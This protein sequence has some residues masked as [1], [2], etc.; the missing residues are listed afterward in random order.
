MVCD[1]DSFRVADPL[2]RLNT[3][4]K[5]EEQLIASK[6]VLEM[7]DVKPAQQSDGKKNVFRKKPNNNNNSTLAHHQVAVL[8]MEHHHPGS[9]SMAPSS[10]AQHAQFVKMGGGRGGD[11]A[12]VKAERSR[13]RSGNSHILDP[14]RLK[15]EEMLKGRGV[16][17]KEGRA[18]TNGKVR[19]TEIS[20]SSSQP[21][22]FSPLPSIQ[23]FLPRGA[24][25]AGS[26][27]QSHTQQ[28]HTL[29][30][31]L[32]SQSPVQSVVDQEHDVFRVDL[33]TN[34]ISITSTHCPA[35]SADTE[36]TSVMRGMM[37]PDGARVSTSS[38]TSDSSY[39]KLIRR[40]Q[41]DHSYSKNSHKSHPSGK[42]RNTVKEDSS[43]CSTDPGYLQHVQASNQFSPQS[44]IPVC[45]DSSDVDAAHQNMSF[46]L[47]DQDIMSAVRQVMLDLPDNVDLQAGE[48]HPLHPHQHLKT[49]DD[50][51]I[52]QERVVINLN[53]T[54]GFHL[55]P[56]LQPYVLAM[57]EQH[58]VSVTA[59][60]A[61]Q[62]APHSAVCCVTEESKDSDSSLENSDISDSRKDVVSVPGWFGKGLR[63]KRKRT[64]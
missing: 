57:Q 1:S 55:Q 21:A 6:K 23:N 38:C 53:S 46:I 64:M 35:K 13:P 56:S 15:L 60:S 39:A 3:P 33:S 19:Q 32:P 4:V 51:N 43:P 16:G 61:E 36:S 27:W 45:S 7:L 25:E 52:P 41:F 26:Q 47:S 8:K 63:I 44:V 58:G 2:F 54:A 18:A 42:V 29:L 62:P 11:P 30:S 34:P 5:S 12:A 28:S 40:I 10:T 20:I 17:K 49:S 22:P 50:S 59:T 9:A 48:G 24:T 14:V 31:I 37:V